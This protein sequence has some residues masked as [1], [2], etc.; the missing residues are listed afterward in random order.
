MAGLLDTGAQMQATPRT[1]R[2][3]G[4]LAD[5]LES[6]DG[7]AR[8]PFGYDN[9][10]VGLL[11]D[12]LAV[13]QVQRTLDRLS[14]SEPLT[15]GAGQAAS[16]R[17]DTADAVAVALP[18]VLAWP[19]RALGAAG[20]LASGAADAGSTLAAID[21]ASKARLVADLAAGK[22]SGTYRLGDV[23]PGQARGLLDLA[24]KMAPAD[25]PRDVWMTDRAFDHILGNRLR[26][27][28][29][30]PEEIGQFA[31]QALAP[32][33]ATGANTGT[34]GSRYP[35][36]VNPGMVDMPT[37]RRY[38]AVMPLD[39]GP[40]GFN[41]VTVVPDGLRPRKKNPPRP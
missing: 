8:K 30:A 22:G 20:L 1:N 21:P 4:L 12:A 29:Y 15:T 9:P 27:D 24:G 34:A 18:G 39:A 41:V 6:V 17:P 36:L 40:E 5:A 26:Q 23:T 13:P 7:F 10:P 32:R 14:Y 3:A 33:A 38:D 28:G 35:T 11:L 31:K 16:L 37:G 19:R 2:L 25:A